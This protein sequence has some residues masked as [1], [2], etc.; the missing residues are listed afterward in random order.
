M[1]ILFLD[2]QLEIYR[3]N[4][5][6]NVLPDNSHSPTRSTLFIDISAAAYSLTTQ[7]TNSEKDTAISLALS[8]DLRL[9]IHCRLTSR[10]LHEGV[11]TGICYRESDSSRVQ[12]LVLDGE[13][14]RE[15]GDK[16]TDKVAEIVEDSVRLP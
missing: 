10:A 5:S 12:G 3:Q 7:R 4:C 6:M 8:F 1:L 16:R 11:L 13:D 2:F 14:T 15:D 9:A